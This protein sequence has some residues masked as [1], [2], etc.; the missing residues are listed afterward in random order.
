MADGITG[1]TGTAVDVGMAVADGKA[2]LSTGKAVIGVV[3]KALGV[4]FGMVGV[5][6]NGSA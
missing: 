3:G 1:V 5:A 6:G 2:T 4:A